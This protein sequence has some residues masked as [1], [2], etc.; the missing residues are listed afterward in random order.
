MSGDMLTTSYP[1]TFE[2]RFSVRLVEVMQA[3]PPG[4]AALETEFGYDWVN[5]GIIPKNQWS[6]AIQGHASTQGGI[7]FKVGRA[8]T[9]ELSLPEVDRFFQICQAVFGS[10]FT[11]LVIYDST[12]RVLYSRIQLEIEGHR[13][14]LGGHRLFWWLFPK[15]RREQFLYKPYY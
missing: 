7:A 14:R 12:G 15:R 10:H 13:V 11:E 4:T 3:L 6:A 8:T 5:F 1:P 9:V 2:E